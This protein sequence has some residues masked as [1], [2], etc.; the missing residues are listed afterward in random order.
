MRP[1]FARRQ[2]LERARGDPERPRAIE[3]SWSAARANTAQTG[4]STDTVNRRG[5]MPVWQ[6]HRLP[7]SPQDLPPLCSLYSPADNEK[8]AMNVVDGPAF[9]R[10]ASGGG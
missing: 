10:R 9:L 4:L 5:A 1:H 8:D 7:D 6:R 3:G 2:A